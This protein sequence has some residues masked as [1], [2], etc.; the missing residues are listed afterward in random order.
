[1]LARSLRPPQ[2]R[3]PLALEYHKPEGAIK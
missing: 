2:R 3:D 1:M